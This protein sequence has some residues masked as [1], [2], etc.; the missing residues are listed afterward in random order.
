VAAGDNC[1]ACS[2]DGSDM[3]V[4]SARLIE[5]STSSVNELRIARPA[6]ALLCAQTRILAM[7]TR[8]AIHQLEV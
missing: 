3:R 6:S 1:D 8:S 5:S 2:S 7:N 4:I